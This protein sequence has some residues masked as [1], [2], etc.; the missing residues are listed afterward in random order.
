MRNLIYTFALLCLFV[1]SA[2][3][4][5]IKTADIRIRDPYIVAD[6]ATQTYYMYAQAA[7]RIG[8][9][10]TGVEVYTSKNLTNWNPPKPVLELPNPQKIRFVWAPEVHEYNGKYY[11]FVTLTYHKILPEEKP[12]EKK[13]WPPM[14]RRGTHIYESDTLFG[15]FKPLK[16]DSHTPSDWMALDGTLFVEE[17]TPYMIFCHEWV[18]TID[19][20]MDVVEL[21]KDLSDSAGKPQ[22]LFKASDAPGA[23]KDPQRG[24]VTDGCFLYRSPKSGRLFMIWSTFIP[25]NGYC[26]ALTHSESGKVHGPWREQK[27]IF[28]ENGGHG[29]IFRTFEG[30]LLVALHQPNTNSK[31]R[32]HLYELVDKGESLE[33]R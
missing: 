28:R 16:K 22:R 25:G 27:I 18:Q 15:P 6:A 12:V 8:S 7:N 3:G 20:S 19:G 13:S 33:I 11:L 17:E 23:I 26:I 9:G 14:N 4:D 30:R 29:M 24:K 31:E 21:K 2:S 32:L 10:F 5:L 1:R